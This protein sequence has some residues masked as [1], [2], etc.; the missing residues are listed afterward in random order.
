MAELA[1]KQ[2]E[3]SRRASRCLFSIDILYNNSR[4]FTMGETG[5]KN[6]NM[7]ICGRHSTNLQ[8]F[9]SF[10]ITYLSFASS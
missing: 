9:M 7:T 2:R 8:N 10:T 6:R 1:E 4:A 3:N 5:E